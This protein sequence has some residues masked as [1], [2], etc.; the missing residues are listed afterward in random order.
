MKPEV[1]GRTRREAIA[2]AALVAGAGAGVVALT[3]P[4]IA[5]AAG[6]GDYVSVR[7]VAHGARGDGVTDD[8]AAIQSACNAA[9][10]S[11]GGTVFFPAGTYMVDASTTITLGDGVCLGGAALHAPLH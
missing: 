2:R 5:S 10:A 8:R 1:E 4:E 7:D 6:G 9:L 3:A 11:G